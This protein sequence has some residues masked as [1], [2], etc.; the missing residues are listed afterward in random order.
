V[1]QE[2]KVYLDTQDKLDYQ[3][4]RAG[5]IGDYIDPNTFLEMWKT[6][7]GNNDTGWSNA[8]YDKLIDQARVTADPNARYELFQQAEDLL[9]DE[10]P[11]IPIYFYTKPYLIRPSVQNWYSTVMDHHP[12]KYLYLD[13]AVK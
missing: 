10:C 3:V 9:L 6:G 5:W 4:S 2:W 1:N 11:I 12:Y 13:P 7:D 8:T